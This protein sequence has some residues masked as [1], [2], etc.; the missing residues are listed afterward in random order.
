MDTHVAM[1]FFKTIVLSHVVQVVSPDHDCPLHFKFLHNS[2]QY[3]TTNRHITSK[4]TFFIDV[5]TL[6]GL[7]FES[8]INIK[9]KKNYMSKIFIKN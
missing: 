2:G 5:R 1:T 6:D 8:V 9:K 7:K 3:A 4:W